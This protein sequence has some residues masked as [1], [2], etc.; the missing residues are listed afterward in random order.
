MTELHASGG[1]GDPEL[2]QMEMEL[3]WGPQAG[4]E[5]EAG[6]QVGTEAGPDLV[7]ASSRDGVRARID[8]RVPPQVARALAAEIDAASPQPMTTSEP[9]PQ[10]E[11]WRLLL[12]DALGAAVRLAPGSGPSYLI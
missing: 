5:A 4:T 3:L 9:P 10:L 1:R 12:E 11:R 2:L 8:R 6:T 7:I